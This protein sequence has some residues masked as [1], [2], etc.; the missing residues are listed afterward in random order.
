MSTLDTFSSSQS[1]N[2]QEVQEI[3]QLAL[4]RQKD[5]DNISQ[6][7][8]VEIAAELGITPEEL[9]VAKTEWE[10]LQKLREKR[11]AFD[12][13]RF[14]QI[15]NKFIRY[16]IT[17][18]LLICLNLITASQITWSG[19]ILLFWG[20]ILALQ[21]WKSYKLQG[22]EYEQAFQKWDFRNEVKETITS[23]WQKIQKSWQI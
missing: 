7:Q 11:Q 5:D 2:S 15:K 17:N 12:Q 20:L 10:K 21:A 19:Y 3:L 8:L 23:F 9:I 4:A 13:Y 14:S 1:Y 16:L 18:S 22:V 6:A